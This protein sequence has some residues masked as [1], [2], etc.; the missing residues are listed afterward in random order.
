LNHALNGHS[1]LFDVVA[2][3]D[4]Q[5]STVLLPVEQRKILHRLG[6]FVQRV[7]RVAHNSSNLKIPAADAE[8]LAQRIFP[9]KVLLGK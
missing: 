7:A 4:H 3:S 8:M 1:E 6:S 2:R 9:R 5:G